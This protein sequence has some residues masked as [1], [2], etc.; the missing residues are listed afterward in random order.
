M[1]VFCYVVCVILLFKPLMPLFTLQVVHPVVR[2]FYSAKETPP[3]SPHFVQV[4]HTTGS[5]ICG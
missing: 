3:R 5:V 2:R 1:S 4:V